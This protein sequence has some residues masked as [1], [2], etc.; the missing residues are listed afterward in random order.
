MI[1]K[2]TI[3][4]P[5]AVL[6]SLPVARAQAAAQASFLDAHFTDIVMYLL[7][8][9][10][11]MF[12]FGIIGIFG[13]MLKVMISELPPEKRA[14]YEGNMLRAGFSWKNLNSMLT[15]AVPIAKEQDIILDHE[16]DGIRELD[17]HLPPWWKWMFYLTIIYAVVYM[18]W[19]YVFN[20]GPDQYE[21]YDR[22]VAEAKVARE[23]YLAG[24]S[25]LIDETNVTYTDDATSLAAGQE[26]YMTFCATCHG[27]QGE[28]KIGP[29]LVDPYWIHGGDIKDIFRT[30]KYGVPEKGMIPWQDQLL[31]GQMS[32]VSSFIKSL[33]GT[34]PP[35]Q[36]EPQGDLY[37]EAGDAESAGAETDSA[38]VAG[39]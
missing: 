31:P 15:N 37:E 29:N 38:A 19:F 12:L 14:K 23:A 2:K 5:A 17:N 27:D 20:L 30:V 10:L 24:L 13:G 16:Y 39:T 6:F 25:N 1:S 26:T 4:L 36:K 28:G 35:N 9:V 3:L 11:V 22:Q 18:A 33:Q 7:I 32:E 8:L 21:R 34:N